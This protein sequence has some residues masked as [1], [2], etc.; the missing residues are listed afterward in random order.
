MAVVLLA[1][2]V[3]Y[4]QAASWPLYPFD[5][6]H[7][8]PGPAGRGPGGYVSIFSLIA[9]WLLFLVWIKTVDWVNHDTR[10]TGM[11]YG[12]W[13][14]VVFFP[15]FLGFLLFA[16]SVPY[17]GFLLTFLT[18]IVPVGVY[19]FMRNRSVEPHERVLTPDHFRHVLA[20][21]ARSVGVKIEAERKMDYEKGAPIELAAMGGQ[22]DQQNQANLIK[23]RQ[24]P[25]FVV[26]KELLAGALDRRSERVMLDYKQNEVEVK[27]QIDGVWH[28]GQPLDR[29]SGDVMLAV[30]KTLANLNAAERR[31]RQEGRFGAEYRGKKYL[32]RITSRGVETGERAIVHFVGTAVDIESL[33]EAGMRPKL[34]EQFK[35]VVTQPSGMVLLSSLPSGGMTT[36]LSLTMKSLDRY[37]RDFYI[38]EDEDNREPEVENVTPVTFDAAQDQKPA[39]VLGALFRKEPDVVVVPNLSDAKTIQMLCA[40]AVEDSLVL[41]TIRAKEAPE[42]LLRVLMLKVPA[43]E[44]APVAKAVLNMRLVRKLCEAC[45]QPYAPTPEMLK[46]LGIPP[47][48]VQSFFRPPPPPENPK[49]ICKQCQGLGYL[50]RTSI[51]EL[52]VVDDKMRQALVSQPK[53]ELLRKLA[54]A[55]GQRGL[56][57]EGL[58]LVARGI[59]S[60]QELQRVLKQ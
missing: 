59:T 19:I 51:F 10:R 23:S 53:L 39:D 21:K 50:G 58:V 2:N 43:K 55:S 37:M 5:G 15:F 44:F 36:T 11:P 16:L 1:G 12:I 60:L 46:K 20:G 54:R 3:A 31:A 40:Q 7:F 14:S 30:M 29:E 41:G 9:Y 33:E 49:E 6:H 52:L 45:R 32:F 25:G 28:N 27:F 24:S 42:A 8:V 34:L 57:D 18:Y 13:N 35:E 22:S 26:A 47:G 48:K 4:G 17:V 38:V 56:Q